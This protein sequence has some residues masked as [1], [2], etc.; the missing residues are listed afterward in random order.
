MRILRSLPRTHKLLLLPVATMVTVLGAHKILTS[1][2]DAR[3]GHQNQDTVLVPLGED[4]S[5]GVPSIALDRAPVAEA[6][7]LASRA[8]DATRE[9]IPLSELTASEI[10][11]VDFARAAQASG[12]VDDA[13]VT[14]PQ[15]DDTARHLAI[16]I[17][18]IGNGMLTD[19]E[20]VVA[21]ATSYE[22]VSSDE[23][24]L[25]DDGPIVL[26]DEI[27]ADEPYVPEW[28]AYTV[29]PGDTFAIMAQENLGLGYSEVTALL[30]TLPEPRMLTHWRAGDRFEYQLDEQGK[31]LSM[32]MMKNARDGYLVKRDDEGALDVATIE[33]TG[34]ATQ[35]LY[36]GTVSGSFARSAQATG[37]NSAEVAELSHV[38]EKKL[39]FRR[40][41]RRGDRFSVLVESDLID[42]EDLDPRV[43]AVSYEGSRMDLTLVR[44]AEDNRFYTPDGE[45][46]DPA[47]DRYPF[48]GHYR[49]SSN[50]NL[51]RHHPVTGRISPHKGTDFAMPSGTPVDA[52]ADGR[53]E[54][55]GNHPLAGRYIVI[56]HDN[57]Y[58]TRYLHL[59]K[60]LVSRGERVTRGERIALS[61]NTG[62]STGA[63]L[64]YEVMVNNTQ[65]DAMKVELPEHQG[66]S[67][68]ALVAFQREAEPM[69]A[70]LE[71][72][73]T[74]TTVASTGTEPSDAS[75]DGS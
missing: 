74:G 36:A 68:D 13:E 49:I 35:R 55:V 9:A 51:R 63:H 18:T 27:D 21:D 40:D 75:D 48:S 10:V 58:K 73:E 30:E 42:G 20:Q 52:P 69:L 72:G 1:V 64:H 24:E 71:S 8:R 54:L 2:E 39:D 61:G 4:A 7:E 41:T 32:R 23:L 67:G 62:R 45:S 17:G 29:E 66:L 37:L 12:E 11:D 53:V 28:L 31:L 16:V 46:L 26:E 34:E 6:I 33:R 59:S 3:Q 15:I 25:F 5:P 50:F 44:N 57:G 60:P 38:L 47:F 65:V 56:R 22:D 19:D 43:L 14:A 70:A